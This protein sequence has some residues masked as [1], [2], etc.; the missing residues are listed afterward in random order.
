MVNIVEYTAFK[1]ILSS[2][3]D[4]NIYQRM[5]SDIKGEKHF[6]LRCYFSSCSM[7]AFWDPDL[8][9]VV[10]PHSHTQHEHNF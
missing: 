7:W 4:G 9:S 3:K 6:T 10:Y 2:Y 8:N 1:N 5:L